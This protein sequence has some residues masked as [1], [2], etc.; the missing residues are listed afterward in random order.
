[1]A[2]DVTQQTEI[3]DLRGRVPERQVLTCSWAAQARRVAHQRAD[4][5]WRAARGDFH[6]TRAYVLVRDTADGGTEVLGTDYTALRLA[7]PKS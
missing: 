1:M 2:H 4:D 7:A 5:G 6:L 3:I